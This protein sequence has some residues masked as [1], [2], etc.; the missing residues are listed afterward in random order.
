MSKIGFVGLGRMGYNMAMNLSKNYE[1]F[2]WNRSK[3]KAGNHSIEF[4]SNIITTKHFNEKIN[5]LVK[6]EYLNKKYIF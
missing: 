1:T 2:V 5:L 4:G 6:N 3:E